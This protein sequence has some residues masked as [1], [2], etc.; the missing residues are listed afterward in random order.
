[1]NWGNPYWPQSQQPP[2]VYVPVPS[3]PPSAPSPPPGYTVQNLREALKEAEAFEEEMGKRK[4]DAEEKNKRKTPEKKPTRP[5]DVI[6]M[7]IMMLFLSGPIAI[8]YIWMMK[9]LMKSV[10]VSLN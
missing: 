10:G 9:E 8:G 3:S 1:M 6:A 7:F 4:K 2:F 5:G